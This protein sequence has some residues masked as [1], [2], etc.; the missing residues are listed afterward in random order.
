MNYLEWDKQYGS[1]F[2]DT[3]RRE[4]AGAD[5]GHGID[6]VRRVIANAMELGPLEKASPEIVLAA[7]W[8]HDCVFVPKNSPDRSRA[9][10]L[11]ADRATVLLKEVDYPLEFIPAIAHA[12]ESHSFSAGIPCQTI[13]AK[14]VQ[15]S[16][17]LES[18]GA[19]GI[20]RCLMTGGSM[21]QRLYH[22]DSPFPVDRE[23]R[24]TEQSVDHFFA[25]LLKLPS[26]M[27]T[28]A[29]RTEA[30][31]RTHIMVEFLRELCKEIGCDNNSLNEALKK[32]EFPALVL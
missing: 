23:P 18:L 20:A 12:I 13:E 31:R 21:N 10:R 30:F 3:A 16:D 24:D 9:S 11:A 6:H 27:Q 29:G 17:R 15:D 4:M 22:P 8:L 14:I 2:C 32:I 5:S 1:W 28:E 7:A 25:K 26:T 19:I